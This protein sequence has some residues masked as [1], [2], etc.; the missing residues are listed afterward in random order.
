MYSEYNWKAEDQIDQKFPLG[1][2]LI[3]TS[4]LNI[5]SKDL[6]GSWLKR[7]QKADWGVVIVNDRVHII[8]QFLIA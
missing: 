3:T 7:H 1:R 5:V 4:V 2:V 6:I 8:K